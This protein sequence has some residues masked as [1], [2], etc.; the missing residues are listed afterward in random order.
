[1]R[2]LVVAP[3]YPPDLISSHQ[4]GTVTYFE[5]MV[6]GYRQVGAEV[7]VLSTGNNASSGEWGDF[8]ERITRVRWPTRESESPITRVLANVQLEASLLTRY[9]QLRRESRVDLVELSDWLTPLAPAISS[10]RLFLK[11]HG[12]ADFI[13]S[14]NGST[15]SAAQRILDRRARTAARRAD[16]VHAG[17]SVL[18]NFAKEQWQLSREIP[19]TVDPWSPPPDS[20]DPKV[21]FDPDTL[22]I[23]AVGR[24][25]WRKGQ[26]VLLLALSELISSLAGTRPWRLTLIGRDTYTGP[27]GGSYRRFCEEVAADAVLERT[28][29]IESVRPTQLSGI[30][31]AADV[32][33]VCSLDGNY[34]Y[35]T[36]QALCDGACLVTTLEPGARTSPYVVDGVSGLLVP[37]DDV[38]AL[39]GALRRVM[40]E[41][42]ARAEL[43]RQAARV[44]DLVSPARVAQRVL[45]DA[46]VLEPS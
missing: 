34:G 32:T 15:P 26:H 2:V 30:H 4:D 3:Q 20:P 8:G 36:I 44:R 41:P 1:M 11:L 46:G 6:S 18:V 40:R 12:P 19:V 39:A 42:A 43:R 24:L 7:D 25:E 21:P 13:R 10:R 29:W 38:H 27:A 28:R 22:E 23:V 17:A 35:T 5:Q 16:V 37:P 33:V 31:K 9:A 45:S 14:L